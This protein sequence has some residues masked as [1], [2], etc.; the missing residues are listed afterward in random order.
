MVLAPEGGFPTTQTIDFM[1]P[2]T[3]VLPDNHPSAG[4]RVWHFLDEVQIYGR[5][6]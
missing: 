6:L 4:E 1:I 5:P 3:E 2:N